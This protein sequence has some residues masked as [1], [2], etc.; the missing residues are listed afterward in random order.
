[1]TLTTAATMGCRFEPAVDPKHTGSLTYPD[2]IRTRLGQIRGMQCGRKHFFALEVQTLPNGE[3]HF[4]STRGDLPTSEEKR[5]GTA[6]L[7]SRHHTT[8][9]LMSSLVPRRP[10]QPESDTALEHHG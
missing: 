3:L 8:T 9:P 5:P 4:K 7:P 10:A 6:L 2:D 1:M